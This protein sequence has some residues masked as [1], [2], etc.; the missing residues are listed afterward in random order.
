MAVP[1]VAKAQQAADPKVDPPR[2]GVNGVETP[3]CVYCPEPDMA[4]KPKFSGVVLP[5]VTIMTDGKV[6]DPIVVKGPGN[7]LDE[8]AL[9]AVRTWKMKP[10]RG[11]NGKPIKC[12]V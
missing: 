10:A 1:G 12:R 6:T 4:A 9:E 7:G 2:A 11:P 8:K 3:R 5:D